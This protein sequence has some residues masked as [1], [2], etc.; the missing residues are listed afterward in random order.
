MRSQILEREFLKRCIKFILI[1]IALINQFCVKVYAQTEISRS[2]F[3]PISTDDNWIAYQAQNSN[4]ITNCV[5]S[6][7]YGG[8]SVFSAQTFI[9]KMFI[10]PPHY[11]IQFELQFW[12]FHGENAH[13]YNPQS[14]VGTEICGSGSSGEI[15]QISKSIDHFGNSAII[16]IVSKQSSASWGISNFKLFVLKCPKNCHFCDYAG[17]CQSWYRLLTY[18]TTLTFTDGQ[19]WEKNNSP[20]YNSQYCGF[21]Y[22]GNFLQNQVAS[23]NLNLN[24]PH[25]MVKILFT[26]LCSGIN[27]SVTLEVIGDAQLYY[28]APILPFITTSNTICGTYF[29]MGKIYII[30]S[31][32]S[33]PTLTISIVIHPSVNTAQFGISNKG[34]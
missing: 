18:F 11:K 16:I 4:H 32:H 14:P 23:I 2:F 34:G 22:Y 19:G 6:D 12:R 24:T 17:V 21:Q 3:S 9:M 28:Y 1:E 8:R 27:N 29:Q 20:Y 15:D 13:S 7:I 10:M 31:S 25:S 5:T 30:G 33:S 26:F